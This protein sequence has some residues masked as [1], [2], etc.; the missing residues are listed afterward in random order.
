MEADD[1]FEVLAD[2]SS[3]ADTHKKITLSRTQPIFWCA[4]AIGPLRSG[5]SYVRRVRRRDGGQRPSSSQTALT[6]LTLSSP[7]TH[8]AVLRTH[9]S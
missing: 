2:G 3:E 5:R 9:A 1:V 6:S 8:S 4:T 7:S